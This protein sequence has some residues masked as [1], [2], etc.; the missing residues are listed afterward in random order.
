MK[1]GTLRVLDLT[2]P[3]VRKAVRDAQD[4]EKLYLSNHASDY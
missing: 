2:Q 4:A 1:D 3:T